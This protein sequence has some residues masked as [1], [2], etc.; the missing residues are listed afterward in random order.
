FSVLFS[1]II[2]IGLKVKLDM[3]KSV[4]AWFI[5]YDKGIKDTVLWLGLATFPRRFV[6]VEY[7]LSC[8]TAAL[9]Q[10]N[11]GLRE[12][13]VDTVSY[14]GEAMDQVWDYIRLRFFD[15]SSRTSG[16]ASSWMLLPQEPGGRLG[17]E[18]RDVFLR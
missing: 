14:A 3:G 7:L 4:Y 11:Q 10:N 8:K 1:T 17:P 18:F 5:E 15:G 13:H 9:M 12:I 16:S 2:P 6:R